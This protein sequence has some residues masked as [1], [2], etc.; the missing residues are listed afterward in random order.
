MGDAQPADGDY[1]PRT[2]L[3]VVDMQN[4]F[5]DPRGALHVPGGEES[6]AAVNREIDAAAGAGAM[7]VYTQDWHPPE[8]PHF[9]PAGPWPAHCVR[10]TW[11]AE[12]HSGLRIVDDPVVRKGAGDADGYSAFSE[13]H[14][15]DGHESATALGDL[16]QERGIERVVVV[17]LAQDVC[18]KE[19][20][21]D[22][23]RAGLAPAVVA[24][25]TRP[26]DLRPG[27]GQRALHEM[28]DAGAR[29]R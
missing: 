18:V 12:L 17:G 24:D 21:L 14:E 26:V 19:T 28:A 4:D 2:A 9:A 10:G 23:A 6:I 3:I 16:L 11:G 25:A 7:V 22:A 27:D 5:A 29:I 15:A 1:D 8:T 20:V 13:R